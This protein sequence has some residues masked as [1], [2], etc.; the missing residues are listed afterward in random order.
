LISCRLGVVTLSRSSL[1]AC[2]VLFI[3]VIVKVSYNRKKISLVRSQAPT[4]ERMLSVRRI[5]AGLSLV[6]CFV[7]GE[8]V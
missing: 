8:F 3:D 7:A 5:E 2:V 4:M 6:A 1:G